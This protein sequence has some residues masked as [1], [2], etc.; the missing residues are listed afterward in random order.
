MDETTGSR[1]TRDVRGLSKGEATRHEGAGDTG[2]ELDDNRR[3]AGDSGDKAADA[4]QRERARW[5][6]RLTR[7]ADGRCDGER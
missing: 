7:G 1:E 5:G 3:Q 4:A 2:G 6:H